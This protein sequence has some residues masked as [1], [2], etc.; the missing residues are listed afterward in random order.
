M[1]AWKKPEANASGFYLRR[2]FCIWMVLYRSVVSR[3]LP[4]LLN[5]TTYLRKHGTGIRANQSHHAGDD[6]KNDSQHDGVFRDVLP[7]GLLP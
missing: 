1:T 5:S 2:V 6:H 4:L 3:T 7:V